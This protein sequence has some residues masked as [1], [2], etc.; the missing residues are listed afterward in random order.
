VQGAS[1]T[2]AYSWVPSARRVAKVRW[3]PKAVYPPGPH[4]VRLRISHSMR[5]WMRDT[6][7]PE[8]LRA[9]LRFTAVGLDGE[10]DVV[11]RVVRLR[12]RH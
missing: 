6:P 5:A 9:R 12:R 3:T 2:V 1:T 8:R 7:G 4:R 10:A 11:R